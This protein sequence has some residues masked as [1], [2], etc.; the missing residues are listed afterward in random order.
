MVK[1]RS[2]LWA[3]VALVIWRIPPPKIR[4]EAA[5]LEE[6]ILLALR[7]VGELGH[8]ECDCSAI[9]VVV[10]IIKCGRAGV[11]ITVAKIGSA[12][13][14]ISATVGFVDVN[15][16]CARNGARHSLGNI[17]CVMFSRF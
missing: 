7:R 9:V 6:P 11:G 2:V 15:R 1:R 13:G 12:D 8:I 3:E 14:A 16:G 4:L 10:V 17:A 5:L